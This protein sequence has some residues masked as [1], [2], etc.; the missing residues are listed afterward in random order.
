MNLG[1]QT[2]PGKD[3]VFDEDHCA[4]NNPNKKAKEIKVTIDFQVPSSYTKTNGG[5]LKWEKR[6][7]KDEKLPVH[8]EYIGYNKEKKKRGEG[9]NHRS[10]EIPTHSNI[11]A[12][13]KRLEYRYIPAIKDADFFS[14]LR[15]DIYKTIAEVAKESFKKS[16]QSFEQSI[17]DHLE[18]L[19]SD[20]Q[21]SIGIETKMAFPGDLTHIFERLDFLG[22]EKSISFDSRGDGIKVRH[23]PLMLRYM[24]D[25][26]R[27]IKASG[28]SGYN[29]IWGYEEPENNV[30]I[31]QCIE[32]AQQFMDYTDDDTAQIFLTTHSPVFYNLSTENNSVECYKVEMKSENDGTKAYGNSQDLDEHMGTLALLGPKIKEFEK[33]LKQ[34]KEQDAILERYKQES[35]SAKFFVEGE[36]D[37]IIFQKALRVY[38]PHLINNISFETKISGAGDNFVCDMVD[39]WNSKRKHDKSMK[40]SAGIV[41]GD[42][43]KGSQWN[44]DNQYVNC[45]I[46]QLGVPEKKRNYS[47]ERQ[48]VTTCLEMLYPEKIWQ[49]AKNKEYLE[50]KLNVKIYRKELF[51]IPEK[52]LEIKNEDLDLYVSHQFANNGS[53]SGKIKT[54]EYVNSLGDDW[55]QENMRETKRVLESVLSFLFD[56]NIPIAPE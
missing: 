36:S 31:T 7:R 23:I 21:Q 37:K 8:N 12:L 28:L 4:Y 18:N 22:G 26:K 53:Y 6:W 24:T 25:Q 16:S 44:S 14:T 2:N 48:Q 42:S 5:F 33:D 55:F 43:Q 51:E 27:K 46:F 35:N 47:P 9:F 3:I 32:L 41:D 52:F 39:A 49:W 17:G 20:I 10:V 54:A 19:T 11:H 1:N 34:K 40:K 13:L 29:F 38:F 45:K 56:N 50:N 15:G 30:E